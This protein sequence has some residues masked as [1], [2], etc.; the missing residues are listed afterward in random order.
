MMS[1]QEPSFENAVQ[2]VLDAVK[3]F[4]LA[5][6]LRALQRSIELT[7][8]VLESTTTGKD[9]GTLIDLGSLEH[10]QG[11]EETL[12]ALLDVEPDVPAAAGIAQ[13]A[14]KIKL[15]ECESQT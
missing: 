10:V 11:L 4:P 1:G 15:R 13:A 3:G 9:L 2:M 5:V 14:L 6:A 7:K 8:A 12:A